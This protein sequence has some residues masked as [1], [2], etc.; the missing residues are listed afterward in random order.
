MNEKSQGSSNPM[1]YMMLFL[2]VMFIMVTTPIG[3]VLGEYF[4]YVLEPVIGFSGAYP[5]V[6]LILA[7]LIVVFLSSFF[8][9]LFTD[10]KAIGK[11][12]ETT[13][14]FQK[15][16]TKA[17]KEGNTNKVNKLMK[18][19]PQIMKMTTQSQSGMMKPMVFLMVFIIPIFWW[20]RGGPNQSWGFL[21][22]LDY[23]YFT[24]PWANRV[25]LFDHTVMQN[26]LLLYFL[27]SMLF[28]QLM[29][30]G[31]KWISWSDWWTN[32][33]NRIKPS[34]RRHGNNY[35]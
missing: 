29:R 10:W 22:N 31:L 13:K 18:M 30:L 4:G 9:N 2:F 7:A 11:T 12:Q 8:T 28:G 35:Y 27:F 1:L 33:K 32:I 14:A 34:R 19:Q 17:R 23:Y 26:W 20:L 15:E 21:S 3:T 16:I 24:V 6:T 25:S 5:I